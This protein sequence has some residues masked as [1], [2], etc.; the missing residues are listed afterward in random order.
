MRRLGGFGLRLAALTGPGVSQGFHAEQECPFIFGA[1]APH[2]VGFADPQRVFQA[3]PDGGATPADGFR[4]SDALVPGRVAFVDRVE[5]GGGVHPA[6][7][8]VGLPFPVH[9]ERERKTC[10]VGHWGTF[11][12]FI[13]GEVIAPQLAGITWVLVEVTSAGLAEEGAAIQGS[14]LVGRGNLVLCIPGDDVGEC[15]G[16]RAERVWAVD[17]RDV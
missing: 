10:G 8:R 15:C 6:A 3:F 1:S 2:S 4:G 14:G 16:N 5:E 9:N 7:R 12:L 13:V 11:R 17:Q